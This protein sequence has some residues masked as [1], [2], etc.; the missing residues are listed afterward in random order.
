MDGGPPAVLLAAGDIASCGYQGDSATAKL[1][2]GEKGT[3]ATLG[4]NAYDSG[5]PEEFAKCYDP[6]WGRFKSRTR[7][8]I[9]DHEYNKPGTT[10]ELG[11]GAGYFDYFGAAAG[12]RDKGYYS[13]DLG[14]WHV[15]VLNSVC[16]KVGGCEPDSPEWRWLRA[17]LSSHRNVCQLAYWH[18]PRFSSGVIHGSTEEVQPFW[19]LLYENGA[20]VVLNGNEHNYERFAPLTPR[21]DV[22]FLT[23]MREFV[24]GTG[25]RLH[26]PFGKPLPY[27]LVRNNDAYG[28]LKLTL[29]SAGFSWRFL[30]AAGKSFTDSGSAECH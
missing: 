16:H 5:T 27:S 17:D 7:P 20:D 24:V 25:G 10:E 29:R 28:V 26:Y 1:I 13:Y 11:N 30:P 15:I 9:G 19:Q 23:G 21:G 14:A 22:D 18:H 8:A 4:D 3:V 12:P 2:E 6:T